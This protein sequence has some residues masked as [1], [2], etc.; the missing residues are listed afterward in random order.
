MLYALCSMLYALCSM[1]YALC[2]MLIKDFSR[3]HD[4]VGIQKLFDLFHQKHVLSMFFLHKLFLSDPDAMLA[5]RCSTT[6]QGERD[7]PLLCL[8]NLLPLCLFFR[9]PHDLHVEVAASCMAKGISLQ[10]LL[11]NNPLTPF[12]HF[13]IFRDGHSRIDHKRVKAGVV[14]LDRLTDPIPCLPESVSFLPAD[15]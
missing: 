3:V 12:H 10:T 11:L 9:N 15:S 6:F 1:L 14:Y 5:G 7:N 4:S 2:S 13:R 8:S